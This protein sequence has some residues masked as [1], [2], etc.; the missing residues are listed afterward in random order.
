VL[1]RGSYPHQVRCDSWTRDLIGQVRK[2]AKR[3]GREPGDCLWVQLPPW[4]LHKAR[5]SRAPSMEH[6]NSTIGELLCSFNLH[7]KRQAF[8][9]RGPAAT[10]P[11]SHPG[12]AGS[13][14]AGI[15]RG[16]AGVSAAFLFGMEEGRVRF[17]GEPLKLTWE[18]M[19]AGA[20]HCLASNVLW[21][22]FPPFPLHLGC[23]SNG[24]TPVSHAGNRGSSPRRSTIRAHGPRGRHQPGVLG[25]RVQFPVGP[26][27]YGR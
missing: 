12:N 9:S 2:P 20:R 27:V 17:P 1:R 15:T 7:A 21:V 13:S 6:T 8:W 16:F 3:P 25:I 23:W 11:G 5:G 19:Y 4:S 18:R 24:K 10:T 14:P 26:L 22:R